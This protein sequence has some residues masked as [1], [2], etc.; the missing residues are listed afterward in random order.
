MQNVWPLINLVRQAKLS[1]TF[2]ERNK[3]LD[4]KEEF[5]V[6]YLF[7]YFHFSSSISLCYCSERFSITGFTDHIA[8]LVES[9]LQCWV[10]APWYNPPLNLLV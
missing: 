3:D 9:Y 2:S 7:I 4:F 5:D 6:T 10:T 1:F 8:T